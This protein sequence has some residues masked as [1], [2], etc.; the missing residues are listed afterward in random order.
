[1]LETLF[2]LLGGHCIA[3]FVLQPEA[4]GRGKSRHNRAS[5]S[6]YFP[7]WPYWLTAHAFTHATAVM[8]VTQN[9]AFGVAELIL[10]WLIDLAKCENKINLH[11]DQALHVACKLAYVGVLMI[12]G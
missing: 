2:L 10:H 8:L 11:T 9:L 4:M 5:D 7:P 6:P 1:M 12:T 3:D